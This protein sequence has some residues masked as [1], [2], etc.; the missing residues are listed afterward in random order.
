MNFIKQGIFFVALS[1]L[2]ACGGGGGGGTPLPETFWTVQAG[3]TATDKV[4][5][6]EVDA[7]GNIYAVIRTE[8]GIDGNANAGSSDF[9]VV[10][11][12]SAGVLQWADQFGG[13]QADK[14]NGITVSSDAVYVTGFTEGDID[15]G[16]SIVSYGLTDMIVAKYLFDG[17]QEWIIQMG[18]AGFDEAHDVT[19]DGTDIYIAGLTSGDA[20]NVGSGVFSDGVEDVLVL[21]ILSNG[22]IDWITQVGSTLYDKAKGIVV[23]GSS[24]YITGYTFGDFSSANAG[25]RDIILAKFNTTDGAPTG[26]IQFGTDQ[27]DRARDITA[28]ANNIY[29][30][31]QTRGGLDGYTNAGGTCLNDRGLEPCRDLFVKKFNNALV[32]QWTYQA[33]TVGED[34]GFDIKLDG[35]A[36]YIAGVA[37]GSINGQTF[38]GTNDMLVMKLDTAGSHTWTRLR[39][40]STSSVIDEAFGIAISGTNLYA[41]GSST[42]DLDGRTSVGGYD[43]FITKFGTDGAVY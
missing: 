37:A 36:L 32:G 14:A 21:K 9:V 42:G 4:M 30:T 31:G 3:S 5:D 2:V 25:G 18:T 39:G 38:Q 20:N 22:N 27:D 7:N 8:G 24:V 29:I 26:D 41:G 19:T 34:I 43:A 12:N 1:S 35:T 13:A 16:G 33:G 23:Q 40:A 10:K 11:Y 6:I 17:T 28:D 15:D